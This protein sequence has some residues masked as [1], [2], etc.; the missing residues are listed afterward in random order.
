MMDD[1]LPEKVF[2]EEW[3]SDD[4][5]AESPAVR[6]FENDVGRGELNN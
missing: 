4:A 6:D 3:D 2:V 1:G 5:H